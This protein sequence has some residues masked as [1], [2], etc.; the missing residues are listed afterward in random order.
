MGLF[1]AHGGVVTPYD[2]STNTLG[3]PTTIGGSV[4]G[5]ITGMTY[6]P[7]GKYVVAVTTT[8]RLILIDAATNTLVPGWNI[9]LRPFGV[10]DSRAV[11]YIDGQLFVSDGYDFRTLGDPLTYAVFVFDIVNGPPNAAFTATPTTGA[12]PLAVQFTDTTFGTVTSR[13]WNFGDGS[14][15]STAAN[16]SHTYTA[17]GQY[18]ASLT[19]S[20]ANGSN[21][22]T[23]VINVVT[24]PVTVTAV[25]DT[26]ARSDSSNSNYGAQ[27]T[28]QGYRAWFGS[29]TYQPFVRFSVGA[30]PATPVSA[31]VRLYVTD[32]STATGALFQTADATWTENGL[33]WNNRPATAGAQLAASQNATLNQWVEFDVTPV[34]TG[35]GQYSFTLTNANSNL[36]Q[37]SSRQGANA[38]QLVISFG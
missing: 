38:P 14:P 10:L 32:S 9:D 15:T 21:T 36:V 34:V 6:T 13:V 1:F 35:P 19:V 12:A 30:L 16:P 27:A 28:I 25:A 7:D 8:Q 4:P 29:T 11:E 2:Y 33:T 26:Y 18:T 3:T 31:K 24:A 23:Q 22:T 37:F 5:G 17:V 20:N